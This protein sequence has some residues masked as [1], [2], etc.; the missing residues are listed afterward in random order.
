MKVKLM[1]SMDE[2]Y[3]HLY[4]GRVGFQRYF[5][6]RFAWFVWCYRQCVFIDQLLIKDLSSAHSLVLGSQLQCLCWNVLETLEVWCYPYILDTGLWRLYPTLVPMSLSAFWFIRMWTA[7]AMCSF[8]L[9]HVV[10]LC[11]PS[12]HKGLKFWNWEAKQ[13]FHSSLGHFKCQGNWHAQASLKLTVSLMILLAPYHR[14]YGERST[15]PHTD[16]ALI[17]CH[18]CIY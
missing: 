14:C 12:S 15:L 7:S 3:I 9:L 5:R 18:L 17:E 8:L 6:E 11:F 1:L 13:I 10:L 4:N 16:R 2:K